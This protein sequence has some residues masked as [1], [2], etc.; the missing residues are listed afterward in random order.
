[1]I[2]KEPQKKDVE[3]SVFFDHGTMSELMDR[4]ARKA[5]AN[6]KRMGVPVPVDGEN[7]AI[8]YELPD[9][10]IVKEDPWHG[11]NTAPEGWFERFGI[12]PEDQ[13]KVRKQS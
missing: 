13:P 2:S 10:T 4:G 1:M 6:S 7:G 12:A 11:E 8:W 3:Q 5:I 9:G